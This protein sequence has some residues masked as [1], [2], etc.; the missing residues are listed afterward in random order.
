VRYVVA[1]YAERYLL[2]A[3]DSGTSTGAAK[4]SCLWTATAGFERASH[5][6]DEV[7]TMQISGRCAALLA[8]VLMTGCAGAAQPEQGVGR[9]SEFVESSMRMR[10]FLN[11]R[12]VNVLG[13]AASAST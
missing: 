10:T 12:V 2:E 13:V 8:V 3:S 5:D 9:Q 4:R 11:H 6:H 1:A 7:S